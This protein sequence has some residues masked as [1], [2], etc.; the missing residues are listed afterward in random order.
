MTMFHDKLGRTATITIREW[1]PDREKW[2]PDWSQDYYEVGQL[3]Y[4]EGHNWYLVDDVAYLA[5]YA[6]E[7][8]AD[9][10]VDVSVDW[11][12]W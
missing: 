6:K 12:V 7:E 9:D 3:P 8:F 4:D 1:D 2:S 10:A 11:I 5:E